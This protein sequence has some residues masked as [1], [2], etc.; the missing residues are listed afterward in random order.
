MSYGEKIA[1][2][3]YQIN[4]MLVKSLRENPDNFILFTTLEKFIYVTPYDRLSLDLISPIMGMI[5]NFLSQYG[6]DIKLN[7]LDTLWALLDN[8]KK[9]KNFKPIIDG[10]SAEGVLFGH[11]VSS[12]YSQ[13]TRIR[14]SALKSL[15]FSILVIGDISPNHEKAILSAIHKSC[16]LANEDSLELIS[17]IMALLLTNAD[18]MQYFNFNN[19]DVDKILHCMVTS[20]SQNSRMHAYQIISTIQ[21]E[22]LENMV[23][24]RKKFFWFLL[25]SGFQDESSDV[26]TQSFRCLGLW[27]EFK[28]FSQSKTVENYLIPLLVDKLENEIPQVR[29][30]VAWAAANLS[31][32]WANITGLEHNLSSLFNLLLICIRCCQN[33]E[34]IKANMLRAVGNIIS[35]LPLEEVLS[36]KN[37]LLFDEAWDLIVCSVRKGH[38]KTQWNGCRVLGNLIDL[39]KIPLGLQ[40]RRTQEILESLCKALESSPNYKVRIAACVSLYQIKSRE[41]FFTPEGDYFFNV[42]AAVYSVVNNSYQIGN[43]SSSKRQDSLGNLETRY[44]AQLKEDTDKLLER[45]MGFMDESERIKFEVKYVK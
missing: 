5:I 17:E 20:D 43:S 37:E 42:I 30:R 45:L 38:M 39:S 33:Q 9:I 24:G 41:D 35:L 25:F 13:D 18:K 28:E 15:Y 7:A 26:R 23:H 27:A 34:R 11:I 6:D 10:L 4:V 14:L 32:Y 29:I 12:S 21:V 19:S 16:T 2:I 44:S 8:C 22:T 31:D 1:S 40:G 3:I 36:K